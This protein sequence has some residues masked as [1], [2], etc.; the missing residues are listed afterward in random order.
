VGEQLGPGVEGHVGASWAG[1]FGQAKEQP[2]KDEYLTISREGNAVEYLERSLIFLR[3]TPTDLA[4]W[5]WV[6]IALYGALYGFALCACHTGWYPD[7]TIHGK[8]KKTVGLA[9]ALDLCQDKDRMGMTVGGQVLRLTN[10]EKRAISLLSEGSR[11]IF[12]HFGP[13]IF[14]LEPALLRGVIP[15]ALDV[16]EF[17]ALRTNTYVIL[18]EEEEQRVVNTLEA[19]RRWLADGESA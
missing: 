3:E 1:N 5:K 10:G 18:E 6:S 7:I 13:M 16:I 14:S 4:A 11:H 19:A 8:G 15:D 9:K 17:L 2:V 12:E